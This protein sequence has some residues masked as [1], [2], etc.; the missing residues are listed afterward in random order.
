MQKSTLCG[1]DV[2]HTVLI[3]NCLAQIQY[4]KLTNF[5]DIISRGRRN[6]ETFIVSKAF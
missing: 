1:S 3:G 2:T 6:F 4:K 5:C